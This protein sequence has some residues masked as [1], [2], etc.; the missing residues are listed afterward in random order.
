MVGPQIPP[1]L[2]PKERRW[3]ESDVLVAMT[4]PGYEKFVVSLKPGGALIVDGDLVVPD[5]SLNPPGIKTNSIRATEIATKKL[6]RK[7]VANIVVLGYMNSLLHLVTFESLEQ[8]IAQTVPEGMEELNLKALQE[9]VRLAAE[10][11]H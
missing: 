7:I 6:G 8:V 2:S 9:G 1:L 4:Q 5:A 3:L 11:A 10:K